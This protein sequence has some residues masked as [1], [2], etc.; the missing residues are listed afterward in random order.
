MIR[1]YIDRGV[2]VWELLLTPLIGVCSF[3]TQFN[4]I[5]PTCQ[6]FS[7]TIFVNGENSIPTFPIRFYER[8]GNFL[9]S[10]IGF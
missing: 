1:P 7:S 6:G 10:L 3:H 5:P 4:N 9:T 8:G 2:G